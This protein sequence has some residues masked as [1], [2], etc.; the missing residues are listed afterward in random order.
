[1][2]LVQAHWDLGLKALAGAF[3]TDPTADELEGFTQFQRASAS[4][5]VAS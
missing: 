1:M 3:V 2:A 4:A 5:S